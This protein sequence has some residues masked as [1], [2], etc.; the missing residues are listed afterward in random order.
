MKLTPYRLVTLL[1]ILETSAEAWWRLAG[2][3]GQAIVK[4]EPQYD[5]GPEGAGAIGGTLGEIHRQAQRLD[6]RSAL[7]QL[8]R[9]E[10]YITPGRSGSV[11]QGQ[12]RTMLIDLHQRMCDDLD[13]R[14][15][16]S[17]PAENVPYYGPA[18]PLFGKDVEAKFPEMSEDI[19]EAGKCLALGRATAAV[20]HVMRAMEIGVQRFGTKLGIALAT[21]KNWQ[22]ILDEINKA[23]KALDQKA[24]QTKAYAEA[25]AHLYNVKLC[26]RNAVMHPKQTYTAD[27]AKALFS[28]VNTFIRDLAGIL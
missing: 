11:V 27:E 19:S 13:D 7:A 20:F 14:L 1:E 15:F 2:L 24:L 17:V 26:W 23:I 3:I 8:V 22:N 6:L 4:L 28:A 18:E 16:L 10:Q 5:I 12:L 25:S 9:I 21:E